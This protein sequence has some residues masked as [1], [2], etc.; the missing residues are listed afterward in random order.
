MA[1]GPQPDLSVVPVPVALIQVDGT[2]AQIQ[3]LRGTPGLHLAHGSTTEVGPDAWR[4]AGRATAAAITA[5]EATG[6]TV[7]VLKTEAEMQE[8]LA[9]AFDGIDEN[10]VV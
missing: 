1:R 7:T 2:L 4:M 8:Q 3:A 6:A 9:A 5:V 10:P